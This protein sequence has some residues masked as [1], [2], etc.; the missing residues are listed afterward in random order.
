M[1]SRKIGYF[2]VGLRVIEY[3][4]FQ[5]IQPESYRFYIIAEPLWVRQVFIVETK[6]D[7]QK[8]LVTLK[9]RIPFQLHTKREPVID[10]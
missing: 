1:Q 3:P 4:V 5:I 9:L 7:L 2:E 10:E 6:L 8:D